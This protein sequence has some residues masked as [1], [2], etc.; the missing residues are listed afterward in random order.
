[1]LPCLYEFPEAMQLDKA[2]P[3]FDPNVWRMVLS[4]LDRSITLPRLS[5]LYQKALDTSPDD[6]IIWA[7]QHFNI[8]EGIGKHAEG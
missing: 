7:S 3:Y 5:R 4:N 8:Q 2:K 6:K 1:M